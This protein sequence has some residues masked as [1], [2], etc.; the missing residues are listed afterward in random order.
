MTPEQEARVDALKNKTEY[1]Q[2]RIVINSSE[3]SYNY[4]LEAVKPLIADLLAEERANIP[5]GFLRQWIN[6]DRKAPHQELVTN[7]DIM[8]FINIGYGK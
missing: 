7:E 5:V 3:V 2:G 1:R 4:A 6:E 8:R